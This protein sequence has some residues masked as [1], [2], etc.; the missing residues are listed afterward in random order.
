MLPPPLIHVRAREAILDALAVLLP[1]ECAG[2][3]A[4]DRSLCRACLAGIAASPH[5]QVLADGTRVVSALRYEGVVRD[6][7][8]AL[9]E[10]GRTDAVGALAAALRRAIEGAAAHA[11]V[12][13]APGEPALALELCPIPSTRA[14]LRRRG[15][16]PVELLARRAGFRLAPLLA[17]VTASAPQ[18]SLGRA[19]REENLRGT[20]RARGRIDGR[21]LILVDDI[22][23]TGAT[24]GEAARAL[25]AAGGI[26]V[27]AAT[28]ARTPLRRE[29]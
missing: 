24:L 26:V 16:R 1:V 22:V 5:E 21:R 10:K 27:A 29:L 8:L 19:E 6:I 18:K 14:A 25:R 20:L 13:R 3:G 23:T 17:C 7:V 11:T 15:Y 12:P 2:C 9:K 4:P 28:L